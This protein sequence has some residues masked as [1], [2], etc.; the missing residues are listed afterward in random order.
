M[1]EGERSRPDTGRPPVI[2]VVDDD[3]AIRALYVL[4]LELAGMT[5]VE[6]TDGR[7]ALE[8]LAG[9]EID[10]VILDASMPVLDGHETL[11][12]I[13]AEPRTA[14]TTVIFVTGANDLADRIRGLDSGADD[15]LEKP[16]DPA[17]LVARVRAHLRG[18]ETWR[19]VV[20]QRLSARATVARSLGLVP[21][22]GGLT[23]TGAAICACIDR[24]DAGASSA[25]VAFT[26]DDA[27][28]LAATGGL[29]AAGATGRLP[30][31]VAAQLRDRAGTEGWVEQR[32]L[33]P[34][35][36][37]GIP[38]GRP[39]LEAAAFVPLRSGSGPIGVLVLADARARDRG[40]ATQSLSAAMDLA[41][42]VTALV[43]PVL[44]RERR[45]ESRVA[46]M[47][48]RID[49][50]A[51]HPVFQPIVDLGTDRAVGFEALTRFDDHTPPERVFAEA[52][53][54]GLG[55]EL[56]AVTA[57][58][59]MRASASL[60]DDAWL[61][62]NVSPLFL[63]DVERAAAVFARPARQVV[64]EL[65][66]HDPIDDY[67][68]VLAAVE[69]LDDGFLLSVDDAGAGYACLHHVLRLRPSYV[70]LDRG[71]VSGIESDPARQALVAGLG[72][73]AERADGCLIAEG[74]EDPAELA[75]LTEL[76]V[77]LGQGWLLGRPAEAGAH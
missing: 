63:T 40:D 16:L 6:A 75:V 76:G 59:A 8:V 41:P 50:L 20:Q 51:F 52:S 56:E 64:L 46:A 58:A 34:A 68:S 66:E 53:A 24:L 15:Y 65:T 44:A 67:P 10:V 57:A 71:W 31:A 35:G 62:V 37:I 61:S 25:V 22:E 43:R 27:E 14:A 48:R 60:P 55:V 49:T 42:L 5:P 29:T 23:A 77:Q 36:A 4:T 7:A 1:D 9:R 73:F 11:A 47:R 45:D 19:R 12:A 13:R 18:R 26:G 28:L 39:D 33:Q 70:K 17:E 54:L 30:Q 32:T 38:L 2:L 72:D 69:A 21:T 74:I 3:D